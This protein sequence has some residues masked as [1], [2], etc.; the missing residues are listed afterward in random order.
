MTRT[1]TKSGRKLDGYVRVSAVRE[2]EGESFISPDVQREKIAAWATTKDHT[3]VRWHEELDVGG[4]KLD[5]P[6]LNLVMERIRSGETEGIAVAA[7][8]RMSRA[9]VATRSN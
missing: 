1:K 6:K 8:D 5:R 2:R 4:G 7:L 9:G 3:I